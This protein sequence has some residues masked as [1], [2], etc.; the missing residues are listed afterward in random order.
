MSRRLALRAV[1]ALGLSGLVSCAGRPRPA[2]VGARVQRYRYGEGRSRVADLLLP[3]GDGAP[4]RTAVL[5]H[6]GYW[7]AGYDRR[8]EDA[9]A[10]DLVGRGWAV[11]NTD[12]RPVG[13]GGGWPATLDDAAAAVQLLAVAAQ[14]HALPLDR[15][16]V[17]GHSA[18]GQL[19]LV[20]A[21]RA[22]TD[23]AARVRA[24]GVVAQAGVLDLVAADAEGLGGG[25]VAELLGGGAGRLPERYAAADPAQL[26]PLGVPVLAVTG[27]ADTTVPPS[28]SERY[29]AAARA[30]GG[31]VELLV[32]PGE[33]HLAHLD[34]ASAC[35]AAT[36]EWL[37]DLLPG[38]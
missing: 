17:V 19:A 20:A 30:A 29:A 26:V 33:D 10:A 8:L 22:A 15:V 1:A 25:A 21:S 3:P 27:D 9:V 38:Q 36:R 14:E 32:V 34:P 5:V 4:A 13:A 2:D 18:G 23:P 6:G 31:D 35:W 12:Y 16:A 37:E 24:A 11:W 7:R 28:Q